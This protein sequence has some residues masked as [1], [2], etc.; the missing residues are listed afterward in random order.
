[1]PRPMT[2]NVLDGD[3]TMM[4]GKACESAGRCVITDGKFQVPT[5]REKVTGEGH[6]MPDGWNLE[7]SVCYHTPTATFAR[8]LSFLRTITTPDNVDSDSRTRL[9]LRS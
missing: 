8:L 4:R 6:E 9:S 1:M 3:G 2:M 7:L 5:V